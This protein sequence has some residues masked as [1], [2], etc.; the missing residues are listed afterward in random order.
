MKK[1]SEN[2][3]YGLK[4]HYVQREWLSPSSLSSMARCW[5]SY[6][7]DKCGVRSLG[8]RVAMQFGSALHAA[9]PLVIEDQHIDRAVVAFD[10]LWDEELADEKGRNRA[11]AIK[12]LMHWLGEH[13]PEKYPYDLV[14]PPPGA[15]VAADGASEWEVTL[16]WDAGAGLPVV[17][18]V[19]WFVRHRETEDVWPVE[20]KTSARM[21]EWFLSGFDRNP[22]IIAYAVGANM[23]LPKPVRGVLVEGM[24]VSKTRASCLRHPVYVSEQE[25]EDWVLWVQNTAADLQ[26]CE[27]S[28]V[29]P[30][31]LAGCHPYSMF[32][33]GGWGCD[34]ADLCR[35]ESWDEGLDMY[36]LSAE[37]DGGGVRKALGL[38][39]KEAPDASA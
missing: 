34:F 29:F 5:R 21:S 38:E 23:L 36:S 3:L 26:E 35:L 18:K 25:Q 2:V 19:D 4:E 10:G 22:Q 33:C 16:A 8:A 11:G 9:V 37:R 30:K 15:I 24:G 20:F 1:Q 27:E 17:G 39:P 31:N 32:G 13:T 7:F 6:Y 14:P 12:S 28:G